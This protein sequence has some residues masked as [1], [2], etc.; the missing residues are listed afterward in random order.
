MNHAERT[1]QDTLDRFRPASAWGQWWPS[2]DVG[3]DRAAAAHLL[4][5]AGFGPIPGQL[6][7]M[8]ERGHRAALEDLLEPDAGEVRR[9]DAAA[10]EMEAAACHSGRF[11]ALSATWMHRMLR[12]PDVLR[13]KMTLFW[14][15]HFAV[16]GAK[17][18]DA[19]LMAEQLA[20]F[21]RLALGRFG[22][23][24]AA[25]MTDPAMLLWLDGDQNRAGAP[26]ENLARELFEL[27]A[28]GPGRYTENDIKEAARALTGWTVGDAADGRRAVFSPRLHD[29]GEKTI[30]AVTGR[31][32]VGEV[33][34]LTLGQPA[35]S[36]FLIRKLFRFFVSETAEPSD[37]LI[38]P[39]AEGWRLRNFDLR[40][41]LRTM[42]GSRA[43][44]S[45]AAVRQRVKSPVEYCVGLARGLGGRMGTRA[46]T[47]QAAAMGQRLF[48]P[49]DVSGWEGDAAWLT[50]AGLID[51]QNLAAGATSGEGRF[52]GLD[53]ARLAEE[54]ELTTPE[55]ISRFFL[56]HFLQS[57]GHP[58]HDALA[59]ELRR[60]AADAGRFATPRLIAARLAR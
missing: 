58:A 30:F 22:D 10:A 20:M 34:R 17:V 2:P 37:E 38:A 26:N 39:L 50:S 6:E 47:D 43:F 11:D 46:L 19:R 12:S 8:A 41:L 40:W 7:T 28:L 54:H 13:E 21:R 44:Y 55:E 35:C 23:L 36:T 5:R 9:F 33:V 49:P 24:L 32:G 18:T 25:V 45:D 42:L 29:G 51:R 1:P 56:D 27:F 16:S 31:F 52:A 14:H 60:T 53:P 59:A 57:P 4:R 15:G 48:F 3:W